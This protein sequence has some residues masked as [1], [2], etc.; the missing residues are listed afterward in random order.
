MGAMREGKIYLIVTH[1]IFSAGYTEL[2]QYF[3]HIYCTNSFAEYNPKEYPR[4]LVKQMNI[5]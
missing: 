1:G 2:E 4:E 3:E 5:F